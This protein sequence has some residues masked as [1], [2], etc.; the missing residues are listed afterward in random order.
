MLVFITVGTPVAG[1]L[2]LQE[3]RLRE[4]NT[5][6]TQCIG[7][8]LLESLTSHEVHMVQAHGAVPSQRVLNQ[9]IGIFTVCLGQ[10]LVLLSQIHAVTLNPGRNPG[11]IV[12]RCRAIR[13]INLISQLMIIALDSN[14]IEQV[15][16][17]RG[18]TYE[19]VND[20]V[21]GQHLV[22]QQG[23]HSRDVTMNSIVIH[24][25]AI[26]I[27]LITAGRTYHIIEYPRAGII[28]F[29]GWLHVQHT[30]EHIT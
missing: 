24:T 30:A 3:I 29:D 15:D 17:C 26:S 11:L 23:V 8:L 2:Q 5:G 10:T 19:T 12:A 4:V 28:S 21:T 6:S 9:G 22:N 25:V 1:I 13:K 20:G 14:H 27:I 7:I 18:S 16:V